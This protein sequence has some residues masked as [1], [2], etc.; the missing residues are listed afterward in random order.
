M[1]MWKTELNRLTRMLSRMFISIY[2]ICSSKPAITEIV[3]NTEM[4]FWVNSRENW[5]KR[6][7]LRLCSTLPKPV[8]CLAITN[9]PWTRSK[10]PLKLLTVSSTKFPWLWSPSQNSSLWVSSF[11]WVWS[12]SWTKVQFSFVAEIWMERTWRW[13]LC[14]SWIISGWSRQTTQVQRCCQIAS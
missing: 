14:W 6:L 2:A 1:K 10:K 8:A 11:L 3:W 9:L 7:T 4:H 5:P 13:T 12:L